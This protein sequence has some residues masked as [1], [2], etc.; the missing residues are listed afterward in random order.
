MGVA[1]VT[2]LK[3]REANMA[4]KLD[5]TVACER[6]SKVDRKLARIIDK[7][8]PCGLQTDRT[9]SMFE[10]LLESIIYQ[11]LNG[12]VAATITG[13]LKALFPENTHSLRTRRGL[14]AG[15]P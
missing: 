5:H 13:R 3:N 10:A 6:L 4:K 12:N 8:G 14:V 7:A 9:Q 2:S 1:E 11:Q 15:F